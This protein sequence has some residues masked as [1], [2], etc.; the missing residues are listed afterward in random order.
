MQ[1]GLDTER[2]QRQL[3]ERRQA[4]QWGQRQPHSRCRRP[5]RRGHRRHHFVRGDRLLAREQEHIAG[6]LGMPGEHQQ[7]CREVVNVHR[8]VEVLASPDVDELPAFDRSKQLE[9]APVARAVDLG[10]PGRHD[11]DPVAER[12]RQ[13]LRFELRHSVDVVR[14]AR[15]VFVDHAIGGAVDPDRTPVHH[16]ADAVPDRAL[17]HVPAALDVHGPEMRVGHVHLVLRGGEVEDQLDALHGLRKRCPVSDRGVHHPDAPRREL[18]DV[19]RLSRR[20][21]LAQD[22]H[23]S[24]LRSTGQCEAGADETRAAGDEHVH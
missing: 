22:G 14:P 23:P 18:R 9:Q 1:R 24:A 3:H 13:P 7:R 21:G 5:D 4:K 6:R 11:L 17:Q 20:V 12:K 16:A 2:A 15:G 8:M 19:L 10:N